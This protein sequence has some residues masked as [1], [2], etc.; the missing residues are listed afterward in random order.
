ML[1]ALAVVLQQVLLDLTLPLAGFL[2]QRNADFAVGRGHRPRL[3][4]GVLAL[5]VEVADLAEVE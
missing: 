2:V 1:Y 3:K 5:D 4:S